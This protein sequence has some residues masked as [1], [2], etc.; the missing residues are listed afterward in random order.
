M[1]WDYSQNFLTI[2]VAVD[3]NHMINVVNKPL[4]LW[5]CHIVMPGEGPAMSVF[6]TP[7]KCPQKF[8][9][10][11]WSMRHFGNKENDSEAFRNLEVSLNV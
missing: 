11:R 8:S 4:S 5:S 2:I 1:S 10:C 9:T 6:N 3:I 7:P